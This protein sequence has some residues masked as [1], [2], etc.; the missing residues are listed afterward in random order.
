MA[1]QA[2]L[3]V[4]DSHGGVTSRVTLKL[5]ALRF[6]QGYK[7]KDSA[8]HDAELPY[9]AEDTAFMM[10]GSITKTRKNIRRHQHQLATLG[11]NGKS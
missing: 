1:G 9:K 11:C 3:G 2:Q 10:Q 7:R 6:T 4:Q 8:A 5:I